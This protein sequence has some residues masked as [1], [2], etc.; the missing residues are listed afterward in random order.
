MKY[1]SDYTNDAQTELFNKVGAFFAFSNEQ[2]EGKIKEGIKYVNMGA[3]MICPKENAKELIDSL[4][5]IQ[6]K[7]IEKDI[8]DNGI[9]AIIRR[10]LDNHECDYTGDYEPAL[11]V[12]DQYG[13][14]EQQIREVF[15]KK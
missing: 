12:L 9:P 4:S 8:E 2:L 10:E 5:V 11:E 1:L 14:S 15:F 6:D 3:G 13:I 7:G